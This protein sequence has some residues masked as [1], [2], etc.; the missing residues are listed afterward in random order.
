M[1]AKNPA[2]KAAAFLEEVKKQKKA[3]GGEIEGPKEFNKVLEVKKHLKASHEALMKAH[4]A[5]KKIA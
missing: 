1:Q 5:I 3:K 4:K 2:Q